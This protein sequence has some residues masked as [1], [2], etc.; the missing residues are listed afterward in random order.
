M[1]GQLKSNPI[2]IR[3]GEG[4]GGSGTAYHATINMQERGEEKNN[5]HISKG[6]KICIQ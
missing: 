2:P 6:D 5:H 3:E 4:E 1:L